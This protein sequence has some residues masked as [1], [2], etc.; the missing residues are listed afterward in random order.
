[1]KIH[2][3]QT[4]HIVADFDQVFSYLKEH[5]EKNS[6]KGLHLFPEMFLTGYPLQDLCLQ[7][8]FI[9]DYLRLLD[10]INEWSKS[11][12]AQTDEIIIL[13]GGLKYLMDE[14][15]LPESIEN[16]IF[17]LRPGNELV[18]VYT[19]RLLPNYDIFDEKKYFSPGRDCK[20][21]DFMNKKIALLLCEDMWP[22]NVHPCDP[23][24]ELEKS[25]KKDNLSLDL[26]VN[27]SASPFHLGKP[28]KRVERA[29]EISKMFNSPF[30]Y[31]N[32]VGGEDEILFDGQS[33]IV[34]QDEII[35]QGKIYQSELTEHE[36]PINKKKTFK[37]PEY[38][39]TKTNSW[40]SLFN[41][42][43][44]IKNNPPAL[45]EWDDNTC[46]TA[47]KSIGFGIQEYAS[48]SKMNNFLVA[49]SGGIDSSLVLTIMRLFIKDGQNLEAV[50]MPGLFSSTPSYDLSY[51]LA[52]NLGIKLKSIPIKFFHTSIRNGFK[53]SFG[54]P[55]TGLADENIQS[56]LRGT[57]LYA[58]SNQ[59][60]AM[61][62][63]TSNKSELA[64]GYSTLYGDSIGALSVLGDIYKTE[65]FQL[66]K[67]INRKFNN[68][69]PEGIITR[70]P[71]AELRENQTDS[72]SLPPYER[73]DVILEGFLSY[74]LNTCDLINMGFDKNEVEYVFKLYK[75]SEFKRAQFCP[76]IKL[77]Q[78][79]FGFGH[80]VPICKK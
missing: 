28:E 6:A 69:I 26:I 49:L 41:P 33:F 29:I 20:I 16:V 73:L 15:G 66:T 30:L 7:K 19:K 45:F 4:H 54:N 76:I 61:V 32:R 60:N 52:K 79:S 40:E 68:I 1:M 2:V 8:Q 39:K 44:N 58:R 5:F 74:R 46:E 31:I 25:I 59:S 75:N 11:C 53:E 57:L 38:K 50:F 24:Q 36:L 12:L 42:Q 80:R 67:Y 51:E 18:P 37:Q 72:Q 3:H 22:G 63:N 77:K 70:P 17:M 27:L 65:I 55:L 13:M 71:T 56:R 35:W 62:L 14:N 10:K 9:D 23:C 34:D 43:I 21:L 64:V 78:K 47:L 48:K